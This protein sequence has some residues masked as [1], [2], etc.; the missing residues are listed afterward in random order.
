MTDK[1]K[2]RLKR[3]AKEAAQA[4]IELAKAKAKYYAENA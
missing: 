1:D 2:E 4:K 3:I